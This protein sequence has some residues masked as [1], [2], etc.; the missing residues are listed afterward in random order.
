MD[1][2]KN[3]LIID[4]IGLLS[5]LYAYGS[6]AY[7]GGGF[8][9]GIHN[10]LE[11]ASYGIPVVFGPNF[12]KFQEAKDLIDIEAARSISNAKEFQITADTLFKNNTDRIQ[13]GKK[14]KEYV[15]SRGGATQKILDYLSKKDA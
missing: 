6:W 3:I 11:A 14:A 4:T 1:V 10:T 9:T 12:D 15:F 7:I 8:G 13:K 5:S 2:S